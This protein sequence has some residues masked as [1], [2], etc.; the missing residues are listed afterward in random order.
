MQLTVDLAGRSYP[1]YIDS[2]TAA[3]FQSYYNEHFAGRRCAVVTNT[4][5]ASI[6]A[7]YINALK[8]GLGDCPV[9]ELPDGEKYKTVE[10][11]SAILDT[12]V[13]A[14]LDRSSV[15]VA[16]GGGV[17][18]DMAGFAAACF[19]RGI[20]YVQIPTTLLAMVDSSVGGKTAVDHPSGKN[21][22][23]AFHQPSAVWIDIDFLKTLPWRE[24]IAGYAEAFKYA[25]L[26]GR[27][28]FSYMMINWD[29]IL[30]AVT[31]DTPATLIECVKRCIGIKAAIVGQDERETGKRALLNFGHTFAHALEQY[32]GF[33]GLLHGEAVLIGL[34]CAVELAKINGTLPKAHWVEFDRITTSLPQITLPS[35]PD[36]NKIYA[37][38]FADK[39]AKSGALRFILPVAPGES[40][41]VGGVGEMEILQVLE[42]KLELRSA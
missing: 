35:A 16:L 5:I 41:I 24:Y 39:K 33:E 6:Y 21:M 19:M 12:L 42:K 34:G 36:Y 29:N 2:G 37:A 30:S 22:I 11:W 8:T 17:V 32:Y 7:P 23:G 31:K 26:G 38:M 40:A 1:V 13:S 18:G 9:H 20:D 14:R 4:T 10:N 27:E 25:F 28:M 15:V 3:G